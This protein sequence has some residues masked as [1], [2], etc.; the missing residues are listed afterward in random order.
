MT[1][2]VDAAAFLRFTPSPDG[3]RLAA[4]LQ[5]VQWQEARLYDLRTGTHET[6]DQALYVSSASWSPDGRRLVYGKHDAD[7]PDAKSLIMT[8]AELAKRRVARTAFVVPVIAQPKIWIL[9]GDADLA[10]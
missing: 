4:V 8:R 9:G 6:L 3:P 7:D 5:G 10:L 1:L 2:P